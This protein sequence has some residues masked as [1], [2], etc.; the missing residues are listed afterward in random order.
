MYEDGFACRRAVSRFVPANG[1]TPHLLEWGEPGRPALC[2]LH[3]GSAHAHWFDMVVPAFMDRF[4]V[5]ALDQRGHGESDWA[6]PPAYATENFGSDLLAVMDAMGW[7]RMTV[8]GH[9]MGGHNALAF[10]AWH[11]ERVQALVVVD[12]RPAFSEERLGMMHER[13]QRGPRPHASV[14]AAVD[15]F[16]LRPRDTVADPALLRH[17]ARAGVTERAG[18]WVFRF[19]PATSGMRKPVDNWRLVDR[20]TARTLIARAEFSPGLPREMAAR[21]AAAIGNATVVEIPGAYHHLVL[22]RPQ[23]FSEALD[24]FLKSV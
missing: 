16:R 7:E 20:I 24:R 6:R 17:L 12:S 14:E 3:G 10:S 18:A 4:H 19:D 22:D 1:L 15:A 2:F 9:S 13:G 11:P 5:I 21:L 23:E 8:V